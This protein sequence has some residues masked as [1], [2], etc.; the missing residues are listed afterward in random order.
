MK[1]LTATRI[2]A[3]VNYW[4]RKKRDLCCRPSDERSEG[5]EEEELLSS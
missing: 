2:R 5:Y 3:V 1:E 4:Q